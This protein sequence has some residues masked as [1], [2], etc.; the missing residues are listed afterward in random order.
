MLLA[1]FTFSPQTG[2]G[3]E[4]PWGQMM[5]AAVVVTIPLIVL[6]LVFQRRLI[7]GLTAGAVKG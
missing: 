1:I 5:A 2:G 7:A 6:A 3:Y 4:I